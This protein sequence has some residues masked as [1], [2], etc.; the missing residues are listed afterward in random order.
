M[1]E[2]GNE[3]FQKGN[4]EQA[5]ELYSKA[6]EINGNN[7]IYF[8]NSKSWLLRA[9]SRLRVAFLF[10]WSSKRRNRHLNCL[11]RF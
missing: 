3:E 7:A 2:R 6:I 11:Q 5:I 8:S 9:K 4:Y 10:H 1:Q